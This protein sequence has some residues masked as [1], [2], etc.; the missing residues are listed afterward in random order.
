VQHYFSQVSEE[1]YGGPLR[2]LLLW[3]CSLFQ[4]TVSQKRRKQ[5]ILGRQKH[6]AHVELYKLQS[7]FHASLKIVACGLFGVYHVGYF[8]NQP[9]GLSAASEKRIIY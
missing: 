7:L 3:A 6:S 8:H 5:T 1:D 4:F 2:I 9:D